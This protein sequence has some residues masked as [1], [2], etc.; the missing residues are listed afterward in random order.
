LVFGSVG[1]ENALGRLRVEWL[2]FRFGFTDLLHTPERTS[3]DRPEPQAATL[4]VEAW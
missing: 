3:G 1:F 4:T 2:V